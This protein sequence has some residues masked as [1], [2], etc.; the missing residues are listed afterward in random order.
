MADWVNA[1][2]TLLTFGGAVF[3][4]VIALRS[5]RAQQEHTAAQLGRLEFEEERRRQHER[6]AQAIT[7]AVWVFRSRSDWYMNVVNDSALP[8]YRLSV[9]VVGGDVDR[10]I[11]RGTQGPTAPRRSDTLTEALRVTLEDEGAAGVD[12][13]DLHVEL[14]FTDAAGVRWH[15]STDGAL[16]EVAADFALSGAAV[17]DRADPLRG[18]PD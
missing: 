4:G 16:T 14:V 10:V 9:R 2:G 3:A 7:V 18:H 8:I 11:D 13:E 5:Y 6:R 15:R 12:A 17:G 1:V